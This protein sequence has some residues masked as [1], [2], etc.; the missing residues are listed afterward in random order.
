MNGHELWRRSPTERAAQR[1]RGEHDRLR[2]ADRAPPLLRRLSAAVAAPGLVRGPGRLRASAPSSASIRARRTSTPLV[3]TLILAVGAGLLSVVLGVP[4]AW[5]TA[6]SDMPFRRTV[7]GAG[8]ARLHHAAL[9]DRDR[10]HH[11]AR[12]RGRLP[13]P[14]DPGADRHHARARQHL[15]HGRRDL[16]HR[17]ARLPVHLFHDPQR[18]ALGRCVVRGGGAAARRAALGRAAA[19]LS[20]PGR[21]GDH[22][23]RAAFGDRL[24]GALRPAGASRHAGAGR[25]SCR[26]ASTA[27]SAPTRRAGRTPRRCR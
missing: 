22:R 6:R 21:A 3:N 8:G 15:Q 11:P 16:R 19:R 12:P 4:L 2:A 23:R 25:R 27:S 13:Q 10:L 7:A 20:P 17:H 24:D 1:D 9:P 18:A 5:A 26:P 14:P